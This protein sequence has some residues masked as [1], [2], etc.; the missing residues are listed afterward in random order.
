[1]VF[2]LFREAKEGFPEEVTLELRSKVC[3][4]VNL[5]I[6]EQRR[7]VRYSVVRKKISERGMKEGQGDWCSLREHNAPPKV[8]LIGLDSTSL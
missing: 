8:Q 5:V 2:V 1:M 4:G 6:S 7:N 3:E